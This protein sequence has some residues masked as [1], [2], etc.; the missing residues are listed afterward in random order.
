MKNTNEGITDIFKMFKKEKVYTVEDFFRIS[1]GSPK[2]QGVKG[3]VLKM[4]DNMTPDINMKAR[5]QADAQYQATKYLTDYMKTSFIGE[6]ENLPTRM[7]N[8]WEDFAEFISS[9]AWGENIG[10]DSLIRATKELYKH[11]NE[12]HTEAL[13]DRKAGGGLT[14]DPTQAL[15]QLQLMLGVNTIPLVLLKECL[16]ALGK[17]LK[18]AKKYYEMKRE[19][20]PMSENK[21]L[22]EYIMQNT[23]QQPE[24]V[25]IIEIIA[26]EVNET[27]NNL[28]EV[29]LASEILSEDELKNLFSPLAK[30]VVARV[31]DQIGEKIK[32]LVEQAISIEE[33]LGMMQT[34]AGKNSIEDTFKTMSDAELQAVRQ[35]IERADAES[36]HL[37]T[38]DDEVASRVAAASGEQKL[39]EPETPE[40]DPQTT[41][42]DY[43]VE[44]DE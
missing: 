18:R 2:E 38:I 31:R 3:L 29:Q 17:R 1:T 35:I 9:D 30:Q 40:G 7:A 5:D 12:A 4:I 20:K 26:D 36:P 24:D 33:F 11:A 22:Q 27:L 13:P 44:E 39:D 28:P 15:N 10:W 25:S 8:D 21:I 37:N 16:M 32:G 6:I 41:N 23:P 19:S 43:E 34:A 42:T 14:G